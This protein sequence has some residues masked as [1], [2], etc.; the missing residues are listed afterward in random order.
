MSCLRRI[1]STLLL[2]FV[3]LLVASLVPSPVA[4]ADSQV[5]PPVGELVGGY[6]YDVAVQGDYIYALT[7]TGLA[8]VDMSSPS[9]PREVGH[10]GLTG[11]SIA[12]SGIR[13]FIADASYS[14]DSLRIVD[15]SDPAH[16]AQVGQFGPLG[17][18]V[19]DMAAVGDHVYLVQDGAVRIIDVSNAAAPFEAGRHEDDAVSVAVVGTHAYVADLTGLRV[20]DLSDPSSPS[21]VGYYAP[22]YG[23]RRVVAAGDYAYVAGTGHLYVIDVSSS[24]NPTEV[25]ACDVDSLD[26]LALAGDTVCGLSAVFMQGMVHVIDVSD[27][28]DP[29][30]AALYDTSFGGWQLTGAGHFVY[31][32]HSYFGVRMIDVSTPAQPELAGYWDSPHYPMALAVNGAYAYI[33][34]LRVGDD[35][36]GVRVVDLSDPT[37]PRQVSLWSLYCWGP[38]CMAAANGY[39]YASR[40]LASGAIAV[41]DL[42]NPTYPPQI[43]TCSVTGWPEDIAATQRYAYVAVGSDGLR[44]VDIADPAVPIEVGGCVTAGYAAAVAISHRLAYVAAGPAGLV[45]V[46]V[47]DALN[48]V[49]VGSCVTPDWAHDVA[50]AGKHAY[51]AAGAAGLRVIDVSHASR[52]VEVGACPIDGGA[53]NVAVVGDLVYVVGGAGLRIVYVGDPA[54]PTEVGFWNGSADWVATGNGCVYVLGDGLYVFPQPALG[55][56]AGEV[57]SADGAKPVSGASVSAFLGGQLKGT[58]RTDAKGRYAIAGLVPGTYVVTAAKPGRLAQTQSDVAVSLSQ[59][60]LLEFG[61]AR[62]G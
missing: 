13:A 25:G 62:S 49:E 60:T 47:S 57:Q 39:L 34:D 56:I 42:V 38:Y 12:V 51:V 5:W 37:A 35:V 30:V 18:Y 20:L 44:I 46:D 48:A 27:P 45:V 59:T 32:A 61:L 21:S 40:S 10:L 9:A 43:G 41:L 29:F 54:H 1:A 31:V 8:V 22:E 4:C 33:Y 28:T 3:A 55:G 15:V 16:P 52:P 26:D 11:Y 19:W 6:C 53:R 24:T 50:V 7:S 36:L 23:C 58:A 17:S 2:P 14:S